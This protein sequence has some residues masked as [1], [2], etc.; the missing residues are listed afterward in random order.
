LLIAYKDSKTEELFSDWKK[1]D[2]KVGKD[3][4]RALKKRFNQ[5]MAADTFGEYLATG[6][7]KPHMLSGNLKNCCSISLT[8]NYRLIVEPQAN[9]F[10]QEEINKT[11]SITV[12][13]VVDYHGTKENW[14]ID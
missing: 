1:V 5:L 9:D 2:R 14:I 12:K 3:V 4:T 13:G 11:V 7:G 6:L 8:A 10:T